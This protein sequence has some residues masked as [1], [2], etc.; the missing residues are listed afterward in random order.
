M[1]ILVNQYFL[2]TYCIEIMS[3]TKNIEIIWINEYINLCFF[4]KYLDINIMEGKTLKLTSE[5]SLLFIAMMDKLTYQII[6]LN[7]HE[8]E[9][10]WLCYDFL[11]PKT[12][13]IA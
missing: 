12:K 8:F 4:L 13:S 2:S 9:I 1:N 10:S 3:C 5:D 6:N 7:T 11:K